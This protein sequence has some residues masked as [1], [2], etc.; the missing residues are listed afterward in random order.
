MRRIYLKEV[1]AVIRRVHLEHVL[2]LC[3][4]VGDVDVRTAQINRIRVERRHH[5]VVLLLFA[6]KERRVLLEHSPRGSSRAV[7][8][9]LAFLAKY[10]EAEHAFFDRLEKSG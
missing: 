1:F 4:I 2:A 9:A 3:V 10:F 7:A 5:D 8:R 6:Q